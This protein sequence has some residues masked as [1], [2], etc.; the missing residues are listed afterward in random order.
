M[1]MTVKV[2]LVCVLILVAIIAYLT[3]PMSKDHNTIT[4]TTDTTT[5]AVNE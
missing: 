2:K 1:S 5:T 3:Y 4:D